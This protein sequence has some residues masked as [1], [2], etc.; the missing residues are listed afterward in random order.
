MLQQEDR[1][2]RAGRRPMLIVAGELWRSEPC[3]GIRFVI[4]GGLEGL[5]INFECSFSRYYGG[6]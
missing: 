5:P 1:R 4:V 2:S 3:T 6:T